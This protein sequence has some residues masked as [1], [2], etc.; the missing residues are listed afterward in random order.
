MTAIVKSGQ[1]IWDIAIQYCGSADAAFSISRLNN[2]SLTADLTAGAELE[3][4]EVID[5]AVVKYYTNNG[6]EP[7]TGVTVA[8]LEDNLTQTNN[9]TEMTALT[10]IASAYDV[11]GGNADFTPIEIGASGG[12]HIQYSR[13]GM[14]AN[15]AKL[16][17]K[18]SIDGISYDTV[19]VDGEAVELALDNDV[20]SIVLTDFLP[21]THVQ[22]GIDVG[23]AT[24]GSVTVKAL[25]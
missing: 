9:N 23:S 19:E 17:I 6:I 12:I 14:D 13:T 22:I 18:Y 21:G 16:P 4:P 11:S 20:D 8:S 2:I 24:A 25:V 10:T 1:S 5:A 7:A 15:D 3:L